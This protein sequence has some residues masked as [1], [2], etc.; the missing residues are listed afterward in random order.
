MLSEL[1]RRFNAIEEQRAA[2]QSRVGALNEP[3]FNP[4]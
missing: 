3:R 2:L 4:P 1:Q